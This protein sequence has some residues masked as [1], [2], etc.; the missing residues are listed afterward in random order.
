M[1][2]L[3]V[4]FRVGDW[5]KVRYDGRDGRIEPR[6]Q[7]PDSEKGTRRG[8]LRE[9]ES[10]TDREAGRVG[11]EILG[12]DEP[13]VKSPDSRTA[14]AFPNRWRTCPPKATVVMQV[15]ADRAWIANIWVYR[16]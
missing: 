3:P 1:A 15:G 7:P 12:V 6:W 8:F 2:Y 14:S 5:M 11:K 4:L 10:R 9:N 16:E 13:K